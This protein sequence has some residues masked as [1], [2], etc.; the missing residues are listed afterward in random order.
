M[1][2]AFNGS[3]N[4]CKSLT[5][6]QG[7]EMAQHAQF[8]V[9]TGVQVYF[10]ETRS[11]WQR[12]SNENTN[13]LLCQYFPKGTGVAALTQEDLDTA[14]HSLNNRPRQPWIGCHHPRNSPKCCNY[15]LR[16]QRIPTRHP[17]YFI[18]LTVSEH[19]LA[20]LTLLR[21]KGVPCRSD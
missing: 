10:C 11:P 13:G 6:D 7:K 16:S 17:T 9:D 21:A 15:P 18:H 20:T 1:T 5:W 8:T 19:P 14:G 12:G 2:L 3:P 4:L